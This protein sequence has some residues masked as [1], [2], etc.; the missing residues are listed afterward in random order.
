[1]NYLSLGG[2]DQLQSLAKVDYVEPSRDKLRLV[3]EAQ[4]LSNDVSKTN[5]VRKSGRRKFIIN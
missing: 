2:T 5:H 3:A 1:M 4:G